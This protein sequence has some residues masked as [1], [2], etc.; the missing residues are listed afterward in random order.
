MNIFIDNDPGY[1]DEVKKQNPNTI[2]LLIDETQPNRDSILC[3]FSYDSFDQLSDSKK[4]EYTL[5]RTGTDNLYRQFLE[6]TRAVE[7]SLPIDAFGKEHFDSINRI[8]KK[9]PLPVN[10]FIDFDRTLSQSE[11]VR[12]PQFDRDREY[13][14]KFIQDMATYLFGMPR[15]V[16]LKKQLQEWYDRGVVIYVLTANPV[17]SENPDF[18][19]LIQEVMPFMKRDHMLCANRK[20]SKGDHIRK[21]REIRPAYGKKK[22][23][24]RRSK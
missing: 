24:V 10:L 3:G 18:L 16:W 6:N 2:T 12:F 4:R 15:R 7:H 9:Y 17:C 19:L 20:I 1:I 21:I 5:I 8:L 23:S 11:G 14:K 13:K 22:K